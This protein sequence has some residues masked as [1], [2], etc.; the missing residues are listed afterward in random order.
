[1]QSQIRESLLGTEERLMSDLFGEGAKIER[2]VALARVRARGGD[3]RDKAMTGL[4]LLNHFVGTAEDIRIKLIM[5]GLESPHHHNAW[6]E[7]IKAAI[8]SK[9]LIPT[10]E[11]RH[12]RTAKSHARTTAVYQVFSIEKGDLVKRLSKRGQ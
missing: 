7:F 8:R 11:R 10:G 4:V 1:M 5:K 9:L 2:D 3:W 12:M 6:G